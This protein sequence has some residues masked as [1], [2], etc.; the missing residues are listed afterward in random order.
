MPEYP[1][2]S[3]LL[4]LLSGSFYGTAGT[5]QERKAR[6]RVGA[7]RDEKDE[8]ELEKVENER[9]DETQK[10]GRRRRS[11][12]MAECKPRDKISLCARA[13]GPTRAPGHVVLVSYFANPAI[14]FYTAPSP[15]TPVMPGLA[16]RARESLIF[17][18]SHFSDPRFPPSGLFGA[19][20]LFD[21][22]GLDRPFTNTMDV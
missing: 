19:R 5:R 4:A 21:V 1:L 12:K 15:P 2:S 18:L 22:K 3:N 16:S 17:L 9:R 10:R 11:T 6:R 7:R 20:L 8:K 14:I 13:R